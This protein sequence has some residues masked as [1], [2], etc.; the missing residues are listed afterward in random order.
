MTNQHDSTSHPDYDWYRFARWDAAVE[1]VENLVDYGPDP[2]DEAVRVGRRRVASALALCVN[3]RAKRVLPPNSIS[4]TPDGDIV[5]AWTWPD[6]TYLELLMGEPGRGRFMSAPAD[7]GPAKFWDAR[8]PV[9]LPRYYSA[10]GGVAI[11]RTDSPLSDD[12]YVMAA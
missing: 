11:R 7:G 12:D 3:Y 5:F 4:T 8:W 6:G 10:G 9:E 2:A 1:A